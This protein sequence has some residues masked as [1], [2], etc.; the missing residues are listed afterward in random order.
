[1]V[2]SLLTLLLVCIHILHSKVLFSTSC[3][4]LDDPS[5][6]FV[7]SCAG[8]PN[9]SL[10]DDRDLCTPVS[11]CFDG[12]CAGKRN[13][14]VTE[15]CTVGQCN[16][17]SG[18]CYYEFQE[19]QT[20]CIIS[21]SSG[22]CKSGECVLP[23]PAPNPGLHNMYYI[24]LF[25]VGGSA[26]LIFI[27]FRTHGWAACNALI[28][29]PVIS[30]ISTLVYVILDLNLYLYKDTMDPWTHKR[31]EVV[32]WVLDA[33]S[34][35][36]LHF[37]YYY[38]LLV[39][40]GAAGEMNEVPLK[41]DRWAK[42]FLIVPCS[43]PVLDILGICSV[44]IPEIVAWSDGLFLNIIICAWN[45]GSALFSIFMHMSFVFVVIH[46]IGSN[47]IKRK[48]KINLLVIALILV[49]NPCGLLLAS[50]WSYWDLDT[51]KVIIYST[52]LNEIL[53]YL[54]L[55]ITI[56]HALSSIT[57]SQ[58]HVDPAE[59]FEQPMISTGN[60]DELKKKS[61]GTSGN[62]NVSTK[63]SIEHLSQLH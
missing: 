43:W 11:T 33:P 2:Q 49:M 16:P 31:I 10:C 62:T 63:G 26:W 28:L 12:V 25:T 58:S 47:P 35:M 51:G 7:V 34:A 1:M 52:W 15:I 38:R 22:V 27:A 23:Y 19:D 24:A 32:Q 5:N 59:K 13:E 40:L 21:G 9:G 53:V 3:H 41:L 56:T 61:S 54:L 37:A 8:L 55:N 46:M 4:S 20:P 60:F 17:S 18:E 29:L 30:W 42:L 14:C 39:A 6:L 57:K 50:I 48:T 44:Y 36:A 45:I